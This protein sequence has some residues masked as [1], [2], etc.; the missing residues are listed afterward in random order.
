[1]KE[2]DRQI[3]GESLKELRLDQNIGQNLLAQKLGLSNSSISYWE[4]GKQEPCA[5][6]IFKLAQY[7][8]VP[9]DYLL[10]LSDDC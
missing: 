4:N 10:G 3:F 8:D 7:F 2:F 6:A 5:T 9:A 1:M